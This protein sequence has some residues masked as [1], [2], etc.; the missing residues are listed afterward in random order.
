M[1]SMIPGA[2]IKID[3]RERDRRRDLFGILC[4][5]HKECSAFD[6]GQIPNVLFVNLL[7]NICFSSRRKAR[8]HIVSV[9]L[10][11]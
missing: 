7:V 6:S 3:A 1:V 5:T 11:L 2:Q 10:K 8:P 9:T 4:S